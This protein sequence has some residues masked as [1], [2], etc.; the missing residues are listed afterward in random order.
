VTVSIPLFVLVG[1]LVYVAWRY[2]GLR[3]WQLLA[4]VILGVLLAA[5]SAGPEITNAINSFVHWLTK[6]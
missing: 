2:A 5:M 1:A 3:L 6:P 4:C